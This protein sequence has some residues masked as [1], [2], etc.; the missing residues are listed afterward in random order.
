M[1]LVSIGKKPYVVINGKDFAIYRWFEPGRHG[2]LFLQVAGRTQLTRE[3]LPSDDWIVVQSRA[4][5]TRVSTAWRK[6]WFDYKVDATRKLAFLG[7]STEGSYFLLLRYLVRRFGLTVDDSTL[8]GRSSLLAEGTS[9][10][11]DYVLDRADDKGLTGTRLAL[12][13]LAPTFAAAAAAE[14]V[15]VSS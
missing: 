9:V 8:A 2:P 6:P 1:H 5:T 11:Y 3:D 14:L 10:P 4:G 13:E 15:G 7:G 12:L